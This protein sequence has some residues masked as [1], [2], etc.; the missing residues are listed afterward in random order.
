MI[1]PFNLFDDDSRQRRELAE[2]TSANRRASEE[3]DRIRV[4]QAEAVIQG[5]VLGEAPNNITHRVDSRTWTTA[6]Y[7]TNW[8]SWIPQQSFLSTTFVGADFDQYYEQ[9]SPVQTQHTR[10]PEPEVFQDKP[11]NIEA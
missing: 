3:R 6:P 4:L 1:F 9:G 7:P 11:R 10:P 5:A 8:Q 2:L